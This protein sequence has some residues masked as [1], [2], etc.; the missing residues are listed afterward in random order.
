MSKIRTDAWDNAVGL[1]SRKYLCGYCAATVGSATGYFH[2]KAMLAIYICPNCGYPT[3]LGQDSVQI[4]GPMAGEHVKIGDADVERVYEEA[5]RC[6]TVDAY[7]ATVMLCRVLLMHIAVEH[8]A[9]PGLTFAGYVGAI[10]TE[11]LIPQKYGKLWLDKVRKL[12]NAQ[13]HDLPPSTKEDAELALKFLGFLL[14]FNE[15][16]RNEVPPP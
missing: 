10:E 11:G 12:G 7:S 14:K 6:M 9:K 3:L 15:E 4:P 8:G 2:G 16:F 13:N 1:S 5:R